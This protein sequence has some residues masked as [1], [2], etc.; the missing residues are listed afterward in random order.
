MAEKSLIGAEFQALPLEYIVSAPLI[1]AVKAQRVAAE[2]TKQFVESLIGTDGTPTTVDFKVNQKNGD[3]SNQI[4][5]NA[6]LLAM[7]PV[8]HL[9]IDSL[10]TRF[11]FEISQ[12]HR[13]TKETSKSIDT[14]V[15][16]GKALS[17]WVSASVKGSISSKSANESSTNRSG[18]L[19]IT[20]QASESEVPEGLARVLSLM[21]SAIQTPAGGGSG[22]SGS[23]SGSRGS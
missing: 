14:S 22:G 3:D 1:A 21:T 23:G 9:R 17:P 15:S 16:S 11:T 2:T 13:D 6:P 4:T 7:V 10:T 12:T 19:D 20:V 18:Q 8:P 5:V